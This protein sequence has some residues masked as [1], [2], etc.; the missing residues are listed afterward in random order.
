[1][2]WNIHSQTFTRAL[3]TAAAGALATAMVVLSTSLVISWTDTSLQVLLALAALLSGVLVFPAL[4]IVKMRGIE[5]DRLNRRL[6]DLTERDPATNAMNA[7][8]FAKA[9]GQYAERRR[10]IAT[11]NG[12]VMISALVGSY[13][14]LSKRYGPEWAETVMKSLTAIIQSS[15]RSGDLVARLSMNELGIFLPGAAAGN[16]LDV[17]QRIRSR[18][19]ASASSTD[20]TDLPVNLKLG[21]TFFDGVA[22]FNTVRQL[23]SEAAYDAGDDEPIAISH[24]R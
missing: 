10:R 2:A 8:A 6:A 16:A 9:V 1:M 4:L 20:G 15:V 21:G 13:D 18:V 5:I 14:E 24:S 11:D 7:T 23:A 19:A 3:G 17:A 12:G 22:E